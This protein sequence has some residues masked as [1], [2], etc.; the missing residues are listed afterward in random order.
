MFSPLSPNK[1]VLVG[2]SIVE[3]DFWVCWTLA[4]IFRDIST[5]FGQ[6]KTPFIF[7]GGTS[8][9]KVYRTIDRFSEDID[10]TINRDMLGF[11]GQRDDPAAQPSRTKAASVLGRI[12]VANQTYV[13]GALLKEISNRFRAM[14][15]TKE[16]W[17]LVPDVDDPAT[18]IFKYPRALTNDEYDSYIYPA[19]RLEFGARGEIWPSS[20]KTIQ[21]YVAEDFPHLFSSID[22]ALE[23]LDGER[24]FWEKATILHEIAYRSNSINPVLPASRLSRHYMIL[25]NW[26]ITLLDSKHF[27]GW[28]YSTM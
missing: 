15:T 20:R 10:L 12:S 19:V 8:L 1:E 26:Q 9:S 13:S 16:R 23:V 4:R 7:K 21:S 3:K 2:T 6:A 5:D 17:E 24:T 25:F 11:S 22:I 28:T 27:L 14:L 18:L